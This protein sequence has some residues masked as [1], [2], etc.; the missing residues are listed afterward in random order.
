MTHKPQISFSSQGFAFSSEEQGHIS[1]LTF[2]VLLSPL[3]RL[4]GEEASLS[5][6][7]GEGF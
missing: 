4:N 1:A 6:V 5:M 7:T 3:R 2:V